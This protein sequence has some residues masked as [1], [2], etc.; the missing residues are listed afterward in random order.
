MWVV[1][2]IGLGV[3]AITWITSRSTSSRTLTEQ[4]QKRAEHEIARLRCDLATAVGEA[5][6]WFEMDLPKPAWDSISDAF[7]ILEALRPRIDRVEW[8]ALQA[9]LLAAIPR[10]LDA[11]PRATP[12]PKARRRLRRRSRGLFAT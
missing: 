12:R 11:Q 10:A 5:Q 1:A 6:R 2:A 4:E 8:S 9:Q 7:A 3:L